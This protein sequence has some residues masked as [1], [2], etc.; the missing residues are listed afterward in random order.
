[1][2]WNFD[3]LVKYTIWNEERIQ[4]LWG[5]YLIKFGDGRGSFL[6]KIMQNYEY[7]IR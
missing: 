3:I 2:L 1:M 6:R 4:V 5:L 7:K